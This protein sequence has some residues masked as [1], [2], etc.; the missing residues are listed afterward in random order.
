[1]STAKSTIDVADFSVQVLRKSIKNLHL[2]VCPPDG[3]VRISVPL[4]IS[5][6]NVRLAVVSKLAWIRK[7][8]AEFDK[9]PR[10][11][12]RYFVDGESHYFQGKRYLLEVKEAWGKHSF[13]IKNNSKMLL[14][15]RPETQM[16]NREHV[17]TEWYRTQLK[18]QVPRL[19]EKWEPI[20]DCEI[21]AWRIQKMKTKWGSCNPETGRIVL[22]L[23]LA[24]KPS[25]CLEYILVHEL[26]HMHERRHNERF[27][28][29]MDQFMPKWRL[30]RDLLNSQPLAHED[31]QY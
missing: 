1:M 6:E 11:S 5:D 14:K 20:V 26:V 3:L 2:A 7:K 8:Q 27:K 4:H 22:N 10:Q 18:G 30:A 15:V 21:S 9:Q 12:K 16:I 24:K 23:E 31:W 25:E 29:M 19:L 13:G 17:V 28:L